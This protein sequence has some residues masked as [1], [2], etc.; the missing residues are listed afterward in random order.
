VS[1]SAAA[2]AADR[3]AT[4]PAL[5]PPA[6]LERLGG[7]SII[8]RYVVEGFM[9]GIHRSVYRGAGDEFSRHR[10]YQQGDDVR[11]VDWKLYG[12]TDRL[13][14]REYRE[15][16]NLQSYLLLDTSLSMGYRD[17]AGVSKLRYASFVAAALAHL[18]L[19]AGDA[20]GLAT[21]G[22]GAQLHLPPRNRRG[23]VHELLLG[24]ERL[25]ATG[26]TSAAAGLDR[27]GEAL[28][29]RGRVILISD[30]L[31]QDD[32][33]ALLAAVARLR[34]RGDEVIVIRPLTPAETGAAPLGSGLYFDPER[35]EQEI[36]ASPEVVREYAA[37]VAAYY[38]R[39]RDRLRE[40]GAEYVGLTTAE[41][42]EHALSAWL[43]ARE[44]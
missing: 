30:L 31:E 20:V 29:R 3:A 18:M 36:P 32:G 41:P 28:R 42:I 5:L 17:A 13:F 19:A 16:S 27:V 44:R 2:E 39:L 35:P 15:D 33:Q 21:F 38:G 9:A 25:R 23:S 40:R 1:R 6:V 24:L 34:G 14:V 12:R 8:H 22:E 10:S 43:R 7:L 37:G 11:R 26:S 4:A